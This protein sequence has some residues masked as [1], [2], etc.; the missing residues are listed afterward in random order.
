MEKEVVIL[1]GVNDQDDEAKQVGGEKPLPGEDRQAAAER[2]DCYSSA[3]RASH[4]TS[5]MQAFIEGMNVPDWTVGKARVVEIIDGQQ[6]ITTLLL[7]Y[8][9]LRHRLQQ[10]SQALGMA[11]DGSQEDL[12]QATENAMLRIAKRL[13]FDDEGEAGTPLVLQRVSDG[14]AL[15]RWKLSQLNVCDFYLDLQ[16]SNE[17]EQPLEVRSMAYINSWLC[18]QAAGADNT[19]QWLLDFKDILDNNI[20]WTTRLVPHRGRGLQ[21]CWNQALANRK[22]SR[23]LDAIKARL[24]RHAET[25]SAASEWGLIRFAVAGSRSQPRLAPLL[26]AD[27]RRRSLDIWMGIEASMHQ[28]AE[29][30]NAESCGKTQLVLLRIFGL[31]AAED[32]HEDEAAADGDDGEET[33]AD[34]DD[35]EETA[36]DGDDEE[37]A[38]QQPQQHEAGHLITELLRLIL[39]MHRGLHVGAIE[40]NIASSEVDRF[41][42]SPFSGDF[43]SWS[44]SK[45]MWEIASY[46]SVFTALLTQRRFGN[47]R[48]IY[49]A[50]GSILR[51]LLSFRS[52]KSLKLDS[53]RPLVLLLLKNVP[54]HQDPGQSLLCRALRQ[55]EFV[56]FCLQFGLK[57]GRNRSG[58]FAHLMRNV[59]ETQQ[60]P[61]LIRNNGLTRCAF[62]WLKVKNPNR[63]IRA[64]VE[65]LL[66]E[67]YTC[68][69]YGGARKDVPGVHGLVAYLARCRLA[70]ACMPD[71]I[72]K[73]F[74]PATCSAAAAGKPEVWGQRLAICGQCC[75]LDRRHKR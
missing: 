23:P 49:Q 52:N 61:E 12:H 66:K 63:D 15:G 24:I 70:A 10:E 75:C 57:N 2:I 29:Y 28:L 64:P 72:V 47:G 65:C 55:V 54:D 35:E 25:V 31:A 7:T 62:D 33:A 51:T 37:E 5:V 36:A 44:L 32:A 56:A 34:G 74:R 50:S 27:E 58:V 30:L 43:C 4:T 59:S 8:A 46:S 38:A 39:A 20:W 6:R 17:P 19:L 41:V 9:V 13:H 16:A 14:Y 60:L 42:D 1:Q 22:I 67:L 73:C 69:I 68:D 21:E 48:H 45:L 53:W 40:A 71:I 18:T 26:Q 11:A 3:L